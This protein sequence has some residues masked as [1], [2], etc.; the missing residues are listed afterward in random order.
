MDRRVVEVIAD[1]G[2]S[3]RDRYR[4]GSGVLLGGHT[5]LTAAHVV[6][7]ALAIVVRGP[8]KR[9]V[10][11]DVGAA[12]IGEVA[13][14]DLAL[15][16][17]PEA[18][19]FPHLPIALI[20]RQVMGGDIVEECWSAGYP[21]F[22]AVK[23]PGGSSVRETV[24]VRGHILPLA[25]LVEGLL[26]LQVS[27]SPRPLP[28][29]DVALGRS[30]WAGMS[31][32]PVFAGDRLVGV[33]TEHAPR[34]GSA[35]I[36]VTPLSRLLDPETA[37][38]SARAWLGRLGVSDPATLPVLPHAV[39]A[40]CLR[41][42]RSLPENRPP[43]MLLRGEFRVV[44]FEGREEELERLLAWCAQDEAISVRLTTAPG[45][46]GKT[47]LAD[48]LC[49][50]LGVG[51]TAGVLDPNASP[52]DLSRLACSGSRC[53]LVVDYAETRSSQVR[54]LIEM[55]ARE[56]A[57]CLRLLLLARSA[58]DWWTRLCDQA[59]DETAAVLL[60]AEHERLGPLP[61]AQASRRAS[62][63]AARDAFAVRLGIDPRHAPAPPDLN[64]SRYGLT[65]TLHMTAL[66]MLLD[67]VDPLHPHP[68]VHGNPAARVLAHERRYW[69]RTSTDIAPAVLDQ[70]VAAATLCG[71]ADRTAA[72]QLLSRLP[73]LADQQRIILSRCVSWAVQM[74]PGD[75]ALAPLQPD[76]LG[77]EHVADVLRTAPEVAGALA[78]GADDAQ[79]HRFLTVLGRAAPRHEHITA[80]LLLL[81]AHEPERRVPAAVKV[82][83]QLPDP[84]PLIA[85]VEPNLTAVESLDA[86]VCI[87][88]CIPVETVA[89]ARLAVIA[90]RTLVNLLETAADS[91]PEIAWTLQNLAARYAMVGDHAQAL[92]WGRRA[93][94]ALRSGTSLK[95][96]A[97]L[98]AARNTV[99][100]ALRSLGHPDEAASLFRRNVNF[101]QQQYDTD[102]AH[103]RR[104]LAEALANL[105]IVLTELRE[106]R[107]AAEIRDRLAALCR[108]PF[109]DTPTDQARHAQALTNLSYTQAAFGQRDEALA[110]LGE[111]E[112]T[113]RP[114][115]AW[116]PDAYG[117]LLATTLDGLT[118]TLGSYRQPNEA[119]ARA[120]E[121]LQTWQDL[122]ERH[123]TRYLANLVRARQNFAGILGQ[124]NHYPEAFEQI[125]AALKEILPLLEHS[126][127]THLDLAARTANN[128][129]SLATRANLVGKALTYLDGIEHW[130]R[131]DAA[132]ERA[133]LLGRILTQRCHLLR[134]A[135]RITEA[136]ACAREAVSIL[137]RAG[138]APL[139][140]ALA[141]AHAALAA[142]QAENG[143][144]DDACTAAVCAIRGVDGA[145]PVDDLNVVN[146]AKLLRTLTKPLTLA[147]RVDAAERLARHAVDILRSPA[148][149]NPA[150]RE[151]L[152]RALY[153]RGVCLKGLGQMSWLAPIQ[154]AIQLL[155]RQ[156]ADGL[157][158]GLTQKALDQC[159]QFRARARTLRRM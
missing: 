126:G 62:F 82:A 89:L 144:L 132:Q 137:Q 105:G 12:L 54:E 145:D 41:L 38:P 123:P 6:R 39:P 49:D 23:R 70:V 125:G 116:R 2:P 71:A 110:S 33:V 111:A 92:S 127:G 133:A 57:V 88:E 93:I 119:L 134:H 122:A 81:V 131:R 142:A 66:A 24:Q 22:Q 121:A 80:L 120:Q 106:A 155:R 102:P 115:A 101:W 118:G 31:G 136:L 90:T 51:W 78:G 114:L 10:P 103:Y 61:G 20:T 47:R 21:E 58:G 35:D 27:H 129:C 45:G 55:F 147:H 141:L 138:E 112:T 159:M 64:D 59:D 97:H 43:S 154:E 95:E 25:G 44:P 152:A 146:V 130:C 8:D 42:R 87:V 56:Q 50:R 158:T 140:L 18:A 86:I 99:G 63:E 3:V 113:L 100:D 16:P 135:S 46:Q 156:Q 60:A 104:P 68:S 151:D 37:P 53:L 48:E 52:D 150:F 40:A 1:L 148:A 9:E 98:A 75:W 17:V 157:G 14:C 94:V 76:L 34:R 11:A 124:L 107:A 91:N 139:A 96:R 26:S 72:Y 77:E 73:D 15:L 85:A 143:D 5:V 67:A 7:K 149:R 128:L 84:A 65:L 36:T 29:K 79:L 28:D 69:Q 117:P 109:G 4:H 83:A 19:E 74:H 30:E 32:A 153:D 108:E 13:R